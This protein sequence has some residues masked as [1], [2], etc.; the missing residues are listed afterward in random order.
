MHCKCSYIAPSSP[1]VQSAVKVAYRYANDW[2]VFY[3]GGLRLVGPAARPAFAA[4]Q[5]RLECR[6][7]ELHIPTVRGVSIQPRLRHTLRDEGCLA[8]Q[9]TAR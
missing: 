7:C 3:G 5:P 9:P 2:G 6:S 4:S 1:V 8:Y